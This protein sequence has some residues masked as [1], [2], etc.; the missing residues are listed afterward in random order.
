MNNAEKKEQFIKERERER[1]K[2][3][4]TAL[5]INYLKNEEKYQTREIT[6]E[7][8]ESLYDLVTTNQ[9]V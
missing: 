5:K 7:S 8:A 4:M 2:Q 1:E 6:E 9:C 3:R